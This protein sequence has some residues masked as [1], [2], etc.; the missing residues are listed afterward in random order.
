MAK[1]LLGMRDLVAMEP[2]GMAVLAVLAALGTQ[3]L[4]ALVALAKNRMDRLRLVKLDRMVPLVERTRTRV[5]IE[6]HSPE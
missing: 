1:V 6:L 5:A 4:V 2:L 3:A